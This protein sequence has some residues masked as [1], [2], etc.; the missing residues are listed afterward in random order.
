MLVQ[1]IRKK[2]NQIIKDF[3]SNVLITTSSAPHLFTFL[4]DLPK[5]YILDT[6][7]EPNVH[8]TLKRRL[9]LPLNIF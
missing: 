9:G 7:Q 1:K 8:K 2:S 5:H 3:P 6:R 4:K